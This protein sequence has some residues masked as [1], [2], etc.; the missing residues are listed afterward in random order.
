MTIREV[1]VIYKLY[2]DI[3]NIL[4]N[5]KKKILNYNFNLTFFIMRT[6]LI[7]MCLKFF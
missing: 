1:F 3:M 2:I 4:Q 6:E 5:K 7:F